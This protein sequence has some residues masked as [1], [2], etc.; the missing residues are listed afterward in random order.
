MKSLDHPAGRLELGHL[1]RLLADAR[2][3]PSRRGRSPS[4]SGRPRCTCSVAYALASTVGS[5]VPGFVTKWPSFIV[6]VRSA[7]SASSGIDSCQRTCESYVQPYS[8]PCC[9]ASCDQLE[10][11]RVRRVGQDGDA[12]AREPWRAEPTWSKMTREDHLHRP[13]LR[14]A[15]RASTGRS[16]RTEPLLFGKFANTLIGPGEAIVLPPE[17]THVDSEAELAVE[18]GRA[19]PPDRRGRRARLHRGLPLRER[20][21]GAEPPVRRQAVDARQGLRH[22]L[23]ARR[24]ARPGVG[25]RRRQRPAR[26]A[27]AERRAVPGRQHRRPRSSACA[28]W[29]RSP[30]TCSRW[31]RAT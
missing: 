2:A 16:R 17:A 23:P 27:A 22:V 14:G 28:A 10:E 30:R 26:R 18:I 4:P 12:E 1:H 8:K 19:R 25:A 5:R 3:A 13:Q 11:A 15:H 24:P 31:S 20:R 7:A 29:S 21:L 9:S 6:D